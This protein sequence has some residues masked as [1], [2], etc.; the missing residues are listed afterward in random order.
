MDKHIKDQLEVMNQQ[1]KELLSIYH[2]AVSQFQISD[3]EFWVWYALVVYGGEFSQQDICEIWSLSKQT[4]NSII[5]NLSKKGYVYLE[6]VAGQGHRKIIR[7]TDE[8]KI[9]GERVVSKVYAAELNS[10]GKM[11]D[12]ERDRCISLVGKYINLLKQELD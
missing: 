8:G 11:S 6:N 10:F 3:N 4:I 2:N 12:E 1:M 5:S 7:M 9:Y